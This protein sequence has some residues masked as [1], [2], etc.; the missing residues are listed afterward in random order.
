MTPSYD[1]SSTFRIDWRPS[2][3]LVAALMALGVLSAIAF[4]MSDL[5]PWTATALATLS[6]VHAGRIAWRE[7]RR[8]ATVLVLSAGDAMMATPGIVPPERLHELRWHLRGPIAVLWAR[9]AAGRRIRLSWWPDTLPSAARRQLR[10]V[11]DR[12]VRYD[13][14]LPSVAA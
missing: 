2:G 9:T 10:L 8:P 13:K 14:P 7:G 11:R 3:A 5:S 6:L 12:G 4:A 1:A